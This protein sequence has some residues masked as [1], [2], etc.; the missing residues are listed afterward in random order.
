MNYKC[1]KCNRVID[2]EDF[3]WDGVYE[4]EDKIYCEDCLKEILG[5][6]E[7]TWYYCSESAN[8]YED[9][10]TAFEEEGAKRIH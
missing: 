8:A 3:Y 2:K 9:L 4:Y 10:P 5:I 1:C 6:E 7:E